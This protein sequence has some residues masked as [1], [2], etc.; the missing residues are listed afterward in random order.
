VGDNAALDG[1]AGEAPGILGGV[2]HGGSV[3]EQLV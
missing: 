3:R 2:E 1:V